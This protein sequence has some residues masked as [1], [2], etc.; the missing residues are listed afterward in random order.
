MALAGFSACKLF[1]KLG[2]DELEPAE[3]IFEDAPAPAL[4]LLN[5]TRN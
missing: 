4:E 2:K 5:L 1:V 3:L